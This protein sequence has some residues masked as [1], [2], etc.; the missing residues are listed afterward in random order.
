MCE[1]A[2]FVFQDDF[3]FAHVLG[4]PKE[5]EVHKTGDAL[6]LTIT[7]NGAGYAFIKRIKEG[8]TASQIPHIKVRRSWHIF[9]RSFILIVVVV[10]AAVCTATAA[11]AAAAKLLFKSNIT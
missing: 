2:S 7:D 10:A 11:S 8:S 1:N 3:I 5:V 4:Q 6:G 9:F